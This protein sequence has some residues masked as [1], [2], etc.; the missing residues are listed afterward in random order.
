MHS[1]PLNNPESYHTYGICRSLLWWIFSS[2]Q[3]EQISVCEDA[4][5]PVMSRLKCL[6][7]SLPDAKI[8]KAIFWQYSKG[9]RRPRVAAGEDCITKRCAVFFTQCIFHEAG[10]KKSDNPLFLFECMPCLAC[11]LK[12]CN[13]LSTATSFFAKDVFFEQRKSANK[14]QDT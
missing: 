9:W 11:L 4:P 8:W 10:R 6:K 5:H 2:S 12:K 3:N 7:I 14:P 13:S 1:Y